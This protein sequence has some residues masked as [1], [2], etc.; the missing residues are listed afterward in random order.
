M[1]Y[2][3]QDLKKGSIVAEKVVIA[4][5][6]FSRLKGLLG[7]KGMSDEEGLII[8]PCSSVHTIGMKISIDV[9]FLS[10][11]NEIVYLIENMAPGRISPHIKK[12]KYVVELHAGKAARS[13]VTLGSFLS[14]TQRKS[15]KKSNS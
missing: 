8:W 1:E 11:E 5:S 12:S 9:L 14:V 3:I 2:I 13:D 6:F 15:P 10:K 4:D 7:K